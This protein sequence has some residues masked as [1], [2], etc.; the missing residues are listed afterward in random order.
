M[1]NEIAAEARPA[2]SQATSRACRRD[3]IIAAIAARFDVL[4]SATMPP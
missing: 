4:T 3:A 2:S 1:V